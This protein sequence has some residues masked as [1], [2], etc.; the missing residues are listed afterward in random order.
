MAGKC[1]SRAYSTRP[2]GILK[3]KY[4]IMPT[5]DKFK[6]SALGDAAR[7]QWYL[8]RIGV[9]PEWQGKGVGTALIEEVRKKVYTTIFLNI[10]ALITILERF[11]G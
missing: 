10:R 1:E 2:S 9:S 6:K 7:T 3:D 11:E 4:Q 5:L 8:Q